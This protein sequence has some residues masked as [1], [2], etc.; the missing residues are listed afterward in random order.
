MSSILRAARWAADQRPGVLDV[1]WGRDTDTYLAG[2]F[3]RLEG[4]DTSSEA[5]SARRPQTHPSATSRTTERPFRMRET[6]S[7]LRSPSASYTTS[8]QTNVLGSRQRWDVSCVQG[9]C[10]RVRA[11]SVR[12]ADKFRG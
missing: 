6:R 3:S 5:I 9:G 2:R 7:T 11:Q 4:V 10:R 8:P 1:G 12:P